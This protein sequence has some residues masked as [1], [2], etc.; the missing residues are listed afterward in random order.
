MQIH[1]SHMGVDIKNV[2]WCHT[3]CT[4]SC[5]L[6]TRGYLRHYIITESSMKPHEVCNKAFGSRRP[7]FVFSPQSK[8]PC[9]TGPKAILKTHHRHPLLSHKFIGVESLAKEALFDLSFHNPR[10]HKRYLIRSPF[11]R[12]GR[13]HWGSVPAACCRSSREVVKLEWLIDFLISSN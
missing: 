5:T 1:P 2:I 11:L 8:P 9:L 13:S 12:G 10:P 7:G 3:I 6:H 4:Y